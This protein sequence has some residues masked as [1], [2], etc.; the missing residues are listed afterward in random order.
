MGF[1]RVADCTTHGGSVANS[2]HVVN[3]SG[4]RRTLVAGPQ[5]AGDTPWKPPSRVKIPHLFTC[6][7]CRRSASSFQ[8]SGS[9]GMVIRSQPDTRGRSRPR[10]PGKN[11]I[12]WMSAQ[13]LP[14]GLPDCDL[15]LRG[16]AGR[17]RSGL[18][19]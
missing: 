3:N 4:H 12:A 1:K 7:L 6:E 13:M 5:A 16:H 9:A 17:H 14:D 11:R 18:R 2:R 19:R 15:T 8:Y 10:L